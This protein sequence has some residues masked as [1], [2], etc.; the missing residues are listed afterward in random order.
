MRELVD[1]ISSGGTPFYDYVYQTTVQA[2]R[3]E[4]SHT[5]FF[6]R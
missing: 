4:I 1:Q 3:V 5:G 2:N 6:H